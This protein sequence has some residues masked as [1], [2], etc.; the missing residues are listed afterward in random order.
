MPVSSTK[1]VAP[2][3]E[4]YV[5]F[6]VCGDDHTWIGGQHMPLNAWYGRDEKSWWFCTAHARSKDGSLTLYRQ[7][8]SRWVKSWEL[9]P[10]TRMVWR[11][12]ETNCFWYT[13]CHWFK[14]EDAGRRVYAEN[15][16]HF[17]AVEH[18]MAHGRRRKAGGSDGVRLDKENARAETTFTDYECSSSAM[19]SFPRAAPIPSGKELQDCR[20]R[21]ARMTD[22]TKSSHAK[23]SRLLEAARL[24]KAAKGQ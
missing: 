12:A 14:R 9:S 3:E 2:L 24:E 18:M 7:S 11:I 10:T 5:Q 21:N 19:N 4:I 23:Y 15:Q 22:Y 1:Y 8:D 17:N 20:A 6:R 16:L 13:P